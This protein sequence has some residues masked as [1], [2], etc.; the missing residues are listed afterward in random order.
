MEAACAAGGHVWQLV[1]IDV[2]EGKVV[3]L[4]SRATILMTVDGNHLQL[5]NALV[6]KSVLLNYSRNPK[7][8]FDFDTTV[9]AR[10]SWHSAMD[11]GTASIAA[12]DGVLAEPPPSALIRSLSNDGAT[13]QFT[14]WIDQ[15]RNDLG[16]TRSEAMRRVRKT[17]RE[18]GILPPD[19][20]QKVM[21]YR[22][23]GGEDAHAPETGLARDTSVDHALDA[24]VGQAR[25]IEDGKDLLD[26]PTSTP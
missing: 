26:T 11:I 12:I 17:L 25:I 13:L 16:K 6:F 18:A 24:Q 1:R 4:T 21:L 22:D 20:V 5:P 3:A 2:H 8:R 9:D 10:S 19:P 15:T 23:A 14:G 7:R